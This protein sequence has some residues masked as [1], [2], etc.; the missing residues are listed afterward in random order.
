MN[1]FSGDLLD[2]MTK[3]QTQALSIF[4]YTRIKC[5]LNQ[6]NRNYHYDSAEQCFMQHT[7]RTFHIRLM[8]WSLKD[9]CKLFNSK[10]TEDLAVYRKWEADP[11]LDGFNTGY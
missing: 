4:E 1:F 10:L 5:I 3:F 11:S 2:E 7:V 6:F 9:F 8:F